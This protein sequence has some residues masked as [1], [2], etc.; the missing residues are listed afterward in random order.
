MVLDGAIDPTAPDEEA[1]LA[2]LVGFDKAL[3]AFMTNCLKASDCPFKGTVDGGMNSISVLLLALESK[4]IETSLDGRKL[5][6]SAALTGLIYPLYDE[7]AWPTLATALKDALKGDG[8]Q[9]LDFADAYNERT[10]E[11]KYLSN[12]TEVNIAVNCLDSR[13]QS[14][15]ESLAK[16][17]A[18][19]LKASPTLGRYWQDGALGCA[20]W[21]Y[22]VVKKP[23]NISA[24]G[25][26]Q[27]LVVGTTGDPATP[28]S[29]AVNLAHHVLA[30]A[31]LLTYVGEGHTAYGRS[32]TCVEKAVDEY[33]LRNVVMTEDIRC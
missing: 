8:T 26:D 29:Q 12:S 5:S 3:R 31:R 33:L 11:G 28:Y 15:A 18:L 32:N 30:N 20:D 17:N 1:N 9:L 21:P 23:A 19:V 10:P 24:K 25:S 27:I 16:Q 22:P 2:Q 14:D 13:S 7:T 6:A 4:P